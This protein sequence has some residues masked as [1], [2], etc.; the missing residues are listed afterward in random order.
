MF[1]FLTWFQSETTLLTQHPTW[2][3]RICKWPDPNPNLTWLTCLHLAC[4]NV[5]LHHSRFASLLC[6]A[7]LRA[8]DR[9]I[10]EAEA[11]CN[12][13]RAGW[14]E[15]FGILMPHLKTMIV[16]SNFPGSASFDFCVSAEVAKK[17]FNKPCLRDL[18]SWLSPWRKFASVNFWWD[19]HCKVLCS[20]IEWNILHRW[21]SWGLWGLFHSLISFRGRTFENFFPRLISV[22]A[23]F[24]R[25]VTSMTHRPSPND[26][27]LAS[28]GRC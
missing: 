28:K 19:Y 21:L 22:W 3:H 1:K 12:R 26:K 4:V 2:N 18:L 24:R 9:R 11:G 8:S 23:K 15:G 14:G 13:S 27:N 20:F 5:T 10:L 16:P 7:F 17:F 6:C 25:T